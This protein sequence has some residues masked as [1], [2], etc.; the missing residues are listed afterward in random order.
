MDRYIIKEV[1]VATEQKPV[2]L[3]FANI[4]PTVRSKFIIDPEP[5]T[6]V[7]LY[8][9]RRWHKSDSSIN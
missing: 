4:H 9:W 3:P 7:V 1:T 6:E 8:P 2:S 5:V